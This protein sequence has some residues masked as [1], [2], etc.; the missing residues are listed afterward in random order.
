MGMDRDS[1]L[2]K[3]QKAFALAGE[4]P[5]TP[6]EKEAYRKGRALLAE[7]ARTEARDASGYKYLPAPLK[8]D[9]RP[10]WKSGGKIEVVPWKEFFQVEKNE[11]V[12]YRI[13]PHASVSNNNKRLWRALYQMYAMYERP[14]SRLERDGFRFRY[15][16]KDA[17]WFDV[18]FRQQDG[19]KK[20]EFYVSTSEYQAKKLKRKMEN[21][22]DVT[23]QESDAAALAVP[24]DNTIIQEMRYL[25]HD[26]FS[27][28]TN[29][30]DS[31]TPIAG[32]LNA[33]DELQDDGDFAR[34]SICAEAENRQKWVRSAGW[35]YEK[36]SKGK[37]PQRA[38]VDSKRA[39]G[40]ARTVVTG[41]INEIND[42]ITDAFQALQNSFLKSDREYKREKVIEKGFSL[43]DEINS[44]RVSGTS[45]DKMNLPVFKTRI[46]IAAHSADRLT[47]E[48]IAE[49][50]GLAYTE[51]ADNN[52][53]AGFR[54]RIGS[55]RYEIIEEMNSLHLSVRTR[56]DTNVNLMS[57]DELSKLAL[58][59]PTA[60]LQRRYDAELSVK[61]RIET[62][63]PA[64]LR[65]VGGI[66]LGQ[67]ER[68]DQS[69]PIHMPTKNADEFYRGYV[70]IGGQGAGKDT[71]IK[72][73]IVEGC[74]KHGIGAII[75]EV[76]V[77]EGE[78]GMADGIRDSLPP[79]KVIDIDLGNDD[80]IVPMDLTEV[81]AKL[82]RKG[83]SRFADEMIDF[84][85]IE[86]LSRTQKYLR[87]AAKASGGSL[88]NIKRIIED[89]NFR[90]DVIEQLQAEGN[91]RLAADLIAWGTNEDL[92]GKADPI[93]NRLDMFFGNDTLYDVFAQPPKTDV[94]FAK[95][96]QEGKVVIIRIPNRKLG[97]LAAKTLV[98]WVT[99]KS[100]MTRML[101]TKQEQQ[102]GCF[103]VF[104][105]P[106]Q[107][108]TEGLTKLM[109][110]IGTEG[111]KERLGS[112]YAF[113]HWNKLPQ[114]LQDNLQGG[115]VQQFLFANDHIRTFE[116]SRH[117]LEPTITVEE[118]ARLPVY[119]A[120]V[121]VR[122][123]GEMQNAFV[124][125]MAPPVSK[126]FPQYDNSF[127]T[128]RHAR[129]YGRHWRD[130][131]NI[132]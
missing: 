18:V 39:A 3:A 25:R 75:P 124:C 33:V 129:M 88:F 77:E 11:M 98:H 53:L 28:N 19:Q 37:V 65:Q 10:F 35:A 71:A 14:G 46:R 72:N 63:I 132:S 55:R 91:E 62:D 61:R 125:R 51:I 115:G 26:I 38:T 97:E 95:W 74:I 82:G 6:E 21:K 13:I 68:K 110:R 102:N 127:L 5:E 85:Q 111:R 73:W 117:R 84:M 24:E 30:Q 99:L 104:N 32:I 113:H 23:I 120:I 105:E 107:Y 96:M 17:F 108:A 34:I 20:V 78:R 4:R 90:M 8:A 29:S 31:K 106:E 112:L 15:R 109:G 1:I 52:E 7:L 118:A 54:V 22:M 119:H 128:A 60:E 131:Q 87:E 89:E 47:R 126:R 121:S 41:I 64:A 79:D 100:F 12:T 101:M 81:I 93:L 50:L 67:A 27:L 36:L 80:Y 94:D 43:E 114:S 76:I 83:A 57:T 92:G 116:L 45:A 48:T 86:G 44:R 103:M 2:R 49:T 16:E 58:Q 69:F 123:A 59:M 42:L 56:S 66:Y 9:K 130:L 70:F 122:A 40:A